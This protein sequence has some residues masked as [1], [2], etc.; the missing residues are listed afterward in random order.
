MKKFYEFS[1]RYLLPFANKLANNRYLSS[2]KDGFVFAMP[3]LIVGSFL[4]LLISLPLRDPEIFL[5]QKWY[6]DLMSA[7]RTKW[8]QPFFV[9]M[10]LTSFFVVFGIGASLSEKYNLNKITGAL[11]SIFTFF[12]LSTPSDGGNMQVAFADAKGIFTGIFCAFLSVEI[13]KFLL[14]K[15]LVI[16]LPESVPPAIIR[17]FESLTPLILIILIFNPINI[18][19]TNMETTLPKY[20]QSL[21]EPLI[22]ASDTL[23]AVLLVLFIIHFLW[24]AGLHG[25]NIV[26]GIITPFMLS[27]LQT[28]IDAIATGE[29]LKTVF[30]QGFLDQ[31]AYIGGSGATLGLAIM[32]AFSKSD[33]LKSI[34]KL[35]IAPGLFNINEPIIFGAPIVMNPI[36]GIPFIL[37]PMINATIA[38]FAFKGGIA[39]SIVALVPWTTPA[40]IAAF[41]A[42]NLSFINLLLSCGLII[43]SG[44]IYY[45][46]VKAYEKSLIEQERKE[47]I[48][49]VEAGAI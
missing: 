38:W 16:R 39:Q 21:F 30:A 6:D 27:N 17:S 47:T 42:S 8:L 1:D 20:I 4:L 12:L 11:L 45:P 24:F 13:Y 35:S 36:L 49:K 34:G 9:S 43:I 25:A 28:N 15:K 2:I 41:L 33:H 5:Y 14:T 48:A 31:F 29:T 46:F 23:P 3:F 32:L 37:V 22:S 40:P 44:F 10:G 26:V 18:F 19:F 7:H